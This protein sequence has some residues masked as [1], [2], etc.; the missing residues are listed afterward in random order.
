M[1]TPTENPNERSDMSTTT[2]KKWIALALLCAVQFMVVLDIAIVNVALPSIQVDLGFSQENL[3]WVLSAYALVFGGFLLLGGRM[4][5]ILGRRRLFLAGLAVFTLG[6]LLCGLA[7]D[8]ASLIGGRAV[9]GLGAAIISPAALSILMTTFREGKERNIALGAWGAVGGFGAAAG[10]LLGGVLTDLVSWE[11]IFFVNIPVGVLGLALAPVFLGESRDARIKRFDAVG[12]FLVTGGLV[13]LVY[14]ITQAGDYGWGSWQTIALF[15][16]AAALLAAFAAWEARL[17]APLVPF[18]IFRIGT[19]ASANVAGFLLGTMLFAM[20]LLLTLYMQ[21]VLGYSPLETGIAYLACAGTSIVWANVAAQLVNRVGVRPVLAIGMA[22][23]TAGLALFTQIS[24]GGSYVTDLLPGLLIVGFGMPF[25][26]VAISIGA[27]A[28]VSEQDAGLASGLINTSQ[29]IGGAL[30]IAALSAVATSTTTDRLADGIAAPVA[31]TDG[32]QAAL[33]AGV[34]VAG[35]ALAAS[36]LL[37]R[38]AP[39]KPP[40]VGA[41]R[42]HPV[43]LVPETEAA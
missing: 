43:V 31:L 23:L 5:D 34:A 36:L 14:A 11:W 38:K 10:V 28:G 16:A 4:A 1:T 19:L 20:F 9:Q 39:A 6:S 32:F 24:P 18:S 3:Q 37:G 13:L 7:W 35:V 22:F 12:A 25:A 33:W 15:G 2:R 40:A 8:E 42:P 17:D 21:Q 30:G 41:E 29:Q 26:F 27:L